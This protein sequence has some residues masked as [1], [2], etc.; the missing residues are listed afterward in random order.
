MCYTPA[1]PHGQGI[2]YPHSGDGTSPANSFDIG[3][4]SRQPW[5][6][7]LPQRTSMVGTPPNTIQPHACSRPRMKTTISVT[8]C[9]QSLMLD[10][11]FTLL[12]K[13]TPLIPSALMLGNPYI[14]FRNYVP[15]TPPR[16]LTPRGRDDC[17]VLPQR[18]IIY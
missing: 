12:G 13:N 17:V 16:M 6:H 11:Q 10:L 15:L 8:Y 14:K 18:N 4:Q 2:S 3:P 9:S 1:R 5:E 7:L